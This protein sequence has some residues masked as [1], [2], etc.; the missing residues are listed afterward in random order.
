[1]SESSATTVY[2]VIATLHLTIAVWKASAL[3]RS[4][5]FA[6]GLQVATHGLGGIVYVVASPLGYRSLGSASGQP[7]LPTLPIYL[8]ILLCFGTQHLLTILWTPSRSDQPW[9]VRRQIVAWAVAYGISLTV[10]VVAFLTTDLGG[11]AHPLKFNTD[12]VNHP[13]VQLFL[14]VFLTMLTC[15]TVHTW[16]RTR[17]ARADDKAIMHSVRWYGRSMLVTSG[18]VVCSAPAAA[19][20]AL[21]H[22]QLDDVGVLGSAFGVVGSIMTCYGV[23]GAA[24]SKWLGERR[25]I[26]VLQPLWDLVVAGVDQELSLGSGHRRSDHCDGPAPAAPERSKPNRIFNVRWTLHRR[27]IEIL[28]GIRQLERRAW[29]SDVPAQAVAGLYG[30]AMRS[31]AFRSQLGLGKKG[32][33][34]HELEAAVT[35]AVLRDAVER[36]QA[37]GP[38]G[39]A[40]S[41]SAGP[42]LFAP[43]KNTPAAQERTRL[44][45]LARALRSPLVDA[46]LQVVRSAEEG[47]GVPR[48]RAAAR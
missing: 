1:M 46:S 21:G 26:A 22:H 32:L 48:T 38:D 5:S 18:Y 4:P 23:S 30:E 14:S 27:V 44:V 40:P 33:S 28:D 31:D 29:I 24:L 15:G 16:R 47:E 36:L 11:S 37:A 9:R 13:Q 19:A 8:G 12:Q 34:P 41:A 17:R 3:V 43:G 6:L 35:A 25:D 7:W 39:A 2:L 20:A 42:A 10:M 45:R